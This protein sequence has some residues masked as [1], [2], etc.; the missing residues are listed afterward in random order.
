M[1]WAKLVGGLMED[2]PLGQVV[3]I[4][5]EKDHEAIRRFSP[6]Q[7]RIRAEWAAFKRESQPPE[8]TV[9][10]REQLNIMQRAF[11]DAYGKGEQV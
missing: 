4:R 1:D 5:R 8:I 3:A 6:D 11:A 9:S 10:Q 7:R 2:T